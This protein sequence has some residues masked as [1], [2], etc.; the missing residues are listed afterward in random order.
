MLRLPLLGLRVAPDDFFDQ[1]GEAL[2]AAGC[3]WWSAYR[4]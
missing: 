1:I 2:P 3:R 4:A